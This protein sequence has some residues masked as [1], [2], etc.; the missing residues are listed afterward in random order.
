MSRLRQNLPELALSPVVYTL[1]LAHQ[2][3]P[4]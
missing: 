2:R 1:S 4:A 3:I